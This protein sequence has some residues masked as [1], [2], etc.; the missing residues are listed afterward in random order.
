MPFK[1]LKM[2]QYI[3]YMQDKLGHNEV[4][5]LALEGNRNRKEFNFID[6]SKKT[7]EQQRKNSVEHTNE[8]P[9]SK[10]KRKAK[11]R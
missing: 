7:T 3:E 2:N 9:Y 5:E 4:L 11:E 8:V 1:T 10:N 6:Y